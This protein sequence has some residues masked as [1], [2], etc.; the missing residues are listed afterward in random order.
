MQSSVYKKLEIYRDKLL[1]TDGSNHS[2]LLRRIRD[3]WC[4]DL[5]IIS[6]EKKV[7]DHA[8]LDRRPIRIRS[9][10]DKSELARKDNARLRYLYRNIVQIER[11]KGLQETYLGFPFL[12]GNVNPEFYVRGPLI[13]FPINLEFRQS[14]WRRR[15]YYMYSWNISAFLNAGMSL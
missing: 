15:T 3:K 10:S 1:H 14:V 2:I 11:E 12:V 9:K 6:S 4:F 5:T 7:V 13:L 8:L